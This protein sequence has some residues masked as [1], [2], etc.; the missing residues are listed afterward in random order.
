[1]ELE[2]YSLTFPAELNSEDRKIFRVK[3]LDRLLILDQIR[4]EEQYETAVKLC[5]R[6]LKKKVIQTS[7]DQEFYNSI[8][9]LP[10]TWQQWELVLSINNPLSNF[11]LIGGKIHILAS[12]RKNP[13]ISEVVSPEIDLSAT[14]MQQPKEYY[15]LSATPDL[16]VS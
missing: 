8:S 3:E 16:E 2:L 15:R 11:S 12:K 13:N 14:I 10:D 9:Q 1:M 6:K 7:K 5:K 4:A